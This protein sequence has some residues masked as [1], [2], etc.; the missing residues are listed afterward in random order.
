[1]KVDA[2]VSWVIYTISTA[3]FYIL[4]AAVLHPQGIVPAGPRVMTTISSIFYRARTWGAVIFLLGA[5]LALFKTIVAN[6]PS[7]GRQIGNTLAIFGALTGS[8]RSSET[9]GCAG[10]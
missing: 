5:G 7:L 8:T 1:M 2:W 6:V 10:S 3:A 4:G 9:A